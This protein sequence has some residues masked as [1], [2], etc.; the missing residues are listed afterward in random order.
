MI[1]GLEK[2]RESAGTVTL[3]V[4]KVLVVDEAVPVRRKL[5]DILH[6]AGIPTSEILMADSAEAALETFALDHPSLVFCELVGEATKGL[7]MVLE[8][9]T[10]DPQAKIVLVTAEDANSPLVRRAIRAGAFGVIRKPLRHEAV[11][12]LLGEIESEEGGIER[13]R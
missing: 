7:D 9:L 10:V 6:R 8:M 4:R 13:F 5:L 3:H 11:R 12:T 2:D 1:P